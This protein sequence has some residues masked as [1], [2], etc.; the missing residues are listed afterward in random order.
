M[1][2]GEWPGWVGL[3]I[4]ML[5]VVLVFIVFGWRHYWSMTRAVADEGTVAR[6]SFVAPVLVAFG[7]PLFLAIGYGLWRRRRS[8]GFDGTRSRR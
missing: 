6:F 8:A 5:W 2:L 7:P 4:V 3:R 1:R